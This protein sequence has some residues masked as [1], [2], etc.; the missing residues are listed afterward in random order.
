[1]HAPGSNFT[2][3]CG[4]RWGLWKNKE[5]SVHVLFSPWSAEERSPFSV[6]FYSGFPPGCGTHCSIPDSHMCAHTASAHELH[7]ITHQ[8]TAA[9]R[10]ISIP[11]TKSM[12]LL[13]NSNNPFPEKHQCTTQHTTKLTAKRYPQKMKMQ[14]N[15]QQIKKAVYVFLTKL[16]ING[17]KQRTWG[18]MHGL[19]VYGISWLCTA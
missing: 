9:T 12:N 1:M 6:G 2:F 11:W 18:A 4:L 16:K 5:K 10:M 7:I 17:H 8:S 19:L 3:T 15:T 14:G 13:Q